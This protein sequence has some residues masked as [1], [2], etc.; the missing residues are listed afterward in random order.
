VATHDEDFARACATRVL[1]VSE[2][3]VIEEDHA[4]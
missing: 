1:R 2:G 4:R 3:L